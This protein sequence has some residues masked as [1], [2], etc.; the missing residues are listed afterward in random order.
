MKLFDKFETR[1]TVPP[2]QY[3]SE[4]EFLNRSGLLRPARIRVFLEKAFAN[5]SGDKNELFGRFRSPKNAQHVAAAFELV[6][7]EL[8]SRRGLQPS[9]PQ[10][11]GGKPDIRIRLPAGFS[12]I[13]E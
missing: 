7:H 11:G 1:D 4:F 3:R 9:A 6:L 2:Q 5:F 12:A 8:M 10:V 13:V